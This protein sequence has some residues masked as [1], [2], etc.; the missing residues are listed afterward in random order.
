M[1]PD[2][3]FVRFLSQHKTLAMEADTTTRTLSEKDQ[4]YKTVSGE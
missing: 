1:D 2:N 4:A 3:S